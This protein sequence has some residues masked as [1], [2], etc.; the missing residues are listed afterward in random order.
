MI[1]N[2]RFLEKQ[3]VDLFVDIGKELRYKKNEIV[4]RPDNPPSGVYCIKK[5]YVK[6]YSITE[7]GSERIHIIYKPNDIFPLTW[8]LNDNQKELFYQAMDNTV[9]IK[10]QKDNFLN[11]IHLNNSV[12]YIL[13]K[14]MM[15][16]FSMFSD[17]INDLEISKTYPRV[18]SS[19]LFFAKRYGQPHDKTNPDSCIIPTPITHQ[20]LANFSTMTRETTSREISALVKKKII[21]YQDH[22]IVVN[23][24]KTLKKELSDSISGY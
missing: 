15:G 6:T 19:I 8:A 1:K 9:L 13:L 21:S 22:L 7:N 10:V 2:D 12:A 14:K 18:I 11:L 17:R 4:I 23:S 5:G 16:M 24:I 20:D 3:F